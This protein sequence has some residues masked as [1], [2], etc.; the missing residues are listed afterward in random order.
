MNRKNSYQK[1]QLLKEIVYSDDADAMA[2]L[3]NQIL[4]KENRNE[5]YD[6]EMRVISKEGTLVWISHICRP[7]FDENGK[8]LGRRICNR[9]ITEKKKMMAD[10]IKAKEQAEESDRLKSSFLANMSHEIRTPMNG[11]MGFAELLKEQ[12]L[13]GEEQQEYIHIIRKSGTRM[14]NII[15]DIMS[16]SKVESGQMEVYISDTNINKQIDYLYTFFKPEAE[17]KGLQLFFKTPLPDKEAILC[18]DKEKI[19][20]ILTNLVKNAIKFTPSGSIEFGYERKDKNLEFFVKDTG[21]GICEEQKNFIFERFRQGS[22]SLS[23]NY[24][25]AGLG[26][27]I[28]KAFVEMLGGKIWVESSEG[29][30][31]IF[32]FTIPYIGKTKKRNLDKNLASTEKSTNQINKLKILIAEDN[33]LS[34]LL[35]GKVIKK[36]Q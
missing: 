11:I 20:S 14:L 34:S 31:S 13:S 16:I 24:E 32:Y 22:E 27:T 36:Y 10:L 6:L 1:P 3:K 26:L 5:V 25:G 21:P 17:Q 18:T 15:N 33:Q 30:G 9:D 19:Y 29:K 4:L 7:I 35:L 12:N 28:S 23:R 8:Y 2:H